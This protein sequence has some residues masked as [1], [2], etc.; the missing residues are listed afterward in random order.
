VRTRVAS[1][2]VLVP[3]V[4]VVAWLDNP[5]WAILCALVAVLAVREQQRLALACGLRSAAPLAYSLAGALVLAALA[6]ER[7][8]VPPLIVIGLLAAY[9]WQLGR[10]RDERRLGDWAATVALPVGAGLLSSYVVLLRGLPGGLS[11]TLLLLGMVWANDTAA[12]VGGRAFGRRPFFPSVSP[13]KTLEGALAGS[14]GSVAVG[15]LAAAL[16]SA[17]PHRLQFGS[18]AAPA[19]AALGLAV[20]VAA[21]LG[22]LAQSYFKRQAN[23]KDSGNLIPG[24]GGV[25]D[26][27][28]SF[29]F[30]APLVYYAALLLGR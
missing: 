10:A 27:V 16:A 11:W 21:P 13:K 3:L 28:D 14:A 4:L 7:D 15:V 29:S 12:Y 30:C 17:Y 22:D 6:P 8:L 19:L 25:L 20:A 18:A 1:A 2:A 23:A 5:W 9:S 26:R 24:H